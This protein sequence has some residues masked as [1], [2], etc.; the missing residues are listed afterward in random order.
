M[1]ASERGREGSERARTL[2]KPRA[3]RKSMC[4]TAMIHHKFMLF[5][6]LGFLTTEFS[7]LTTNWSK[8]YIDFFADGLL[9]KCERTKKEEKTIVS[10][11]AFWPYMKSKESR[12]YN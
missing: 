6:L 9:R 1:I 5:I 3:L 2:R 12:Y 4:I 8:K 11:K 7:K 10:S